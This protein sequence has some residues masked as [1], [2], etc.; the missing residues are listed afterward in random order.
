MPLVIG[1]LTEF[2][3]KV[4]WSGPHNTIVAPA[5]HHIMEGRWIRDS[6]VVDDY[7]RFWFA[8]PGFRKQYTFWGAHALWQRSLLI[9]AS[10]EHGVAGELFGALVDNYHDWIRTHYSPHERCMFQSCHA[11]GEENSAGLDGCRPTIN[12]V[13]YGEALALS[14]LAGSLRNESQRIFFD[15]EARRWQRVLTDRLWSEEK[16]FFMTLTTHPPRT[17]HDEIGRYNRMR[18]GREV[19]TYFGCLA[20]RRG[21]TCPPERGWPAGKLVPPRE[22]MGLSSPWYFSAVPMEAAASTRLVCSAM[23]APSHL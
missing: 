3:R 2:L 14:R 13:M 17:L 9:D 19:Q 4:F 7:A 20:C 6:S 15:A 21:R 8:G 1:V 10:A 12:S 23:P 16:R 18:R 22:L 11:D 5:G